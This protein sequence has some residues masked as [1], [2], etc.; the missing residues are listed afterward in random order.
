MKKSQLCYAI[1]P[2]GTKTKEQAELAAKEI[3]EI[4]Y[5]KFESV[6]Q[7][8]YAYDF[9]VEEYKAMLDSYGLSAESFYFH[10]PVVGQEETFFSNLERELDFVRQLGITRATLQGVYGRP[11]GNVMDEASRQHNL[12]LMIRFANIAQE[13]G[14]KTNVHPH[15]DTYFMYEDEIDYVMENTDKDLIYFAPDTAHIAA[16]GGDPVEIIRRYADRV[17]FTHIK[18]YKLGDDVT[19]KGWVDSGVPVMTCFHGLGLGTINFPEIIKILDSVNYTGPLCIEL[20][21]A[22]ISNADSAKKSYDYLSK[23]LED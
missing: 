22:P 3:T 20:D 5:K 16:A 19:S 21:G 13:Y 9:N 14:I 6:K 15:V 7:A 11:E 12:N 2:W 8:I 18:D 1:W 17:N 4:G 23:F 10:L